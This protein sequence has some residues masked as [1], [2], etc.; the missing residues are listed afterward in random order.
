[1]NADI[2]R[3]AHRALHLADGR[4]ARVERNAVRIA[5]SELRW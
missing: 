5:A 3:M 4:I 1:H 2:A